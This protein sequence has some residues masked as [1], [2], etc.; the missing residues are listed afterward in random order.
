M[1]RQLRDVAA[2]ECDLAGICAEQAGQHVEERRFARAIRAD[3]AVQSI[4]MHVEVHVRGYHQRAKSL[5]QSSDCQ[6]RLISLHGALFD[7]AEWRDARWS[8]R[9][10]GTH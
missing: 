2:I 1:H 9:N 6:Y 3:Q 8:R 7:I 4:W 10:A 5:V